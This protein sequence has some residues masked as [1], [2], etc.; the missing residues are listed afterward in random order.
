LRS[1]SN[2]LVLLDEDDAEVRRL[3]ISTRRVIVISVDGQAAR[4]PT[5][6]ERRVVTGLGQIISAISGTQ[7]NAYNFETLL[8]VD[9]QVNNFT[10]QIKRIRCE[11]APVLDGHDCGD[12]KGGLARVSLAGVADE[13]TRR[14]LQAIPTS[15]TISDADVD[16][17]VDQG[18]TLLQ[19]N[20]TLL[21]LIAD[22]DPMT[23][24]TVASNPQPSRM[25]RR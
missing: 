3:A 4:D 8:L 12:V 14:R 21:R 2:A 24:T 5:L 23:N 18:R 13:A 17:L 9:Q 1:L 22:F 7:I 11:P 20:P 19:T 16:A 15:L 25:R 6:G 10:D